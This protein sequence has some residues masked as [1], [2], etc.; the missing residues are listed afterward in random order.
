MQI[1]YA[2]IFSTLGNTCFNKVYGNELLIKLINFIGKLSSDYA[3]NTGKG[4][5]LS[6]YKI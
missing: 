2:T 1:I 6:K 4:D 5:N 3:L